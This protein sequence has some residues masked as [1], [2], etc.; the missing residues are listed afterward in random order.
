[1]GSICL[2]LSLQL[3]LLLKS[4]QTPLLIHFLGRPLA[5]IRFLQIV[6]GLQLQLVN[7]L[8]YGSHLF[9]NLCNL[10]GYVGH[11]LICNYRASYTSFNKDTET[12][13]SC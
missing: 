2:G 11:L 1:M 3:L 7:L 5:L 8:V 12:I 13:T 10:I 6:L 4:Q 9:L